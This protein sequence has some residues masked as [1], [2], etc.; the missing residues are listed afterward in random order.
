ML[1]AVFYALD[2]LLHRRESPSAVAPAARAPL[3]LEGTPN[4]LL[5]A[6]V[7]GAVLMSGL[8]D[9]GDRV[10]RRGRARSSSRARCAASSSSCSAARRSRSRR[11]PCARHNQFHWA[12]IVEVAKLFAAIFVTIFPVLAMLEAGRDGALAG[13][14]ELVSDGTGSRNNVMVFWL[15]GLLSAFLDNAPTY[16]VFFNLAGGDAA[17]LMGEH[18]Q[19]L[20]ALSMGAVYFGALTYIGNA[21]NF[22]IKAIAEDRGVAMPSFFAFFF[23]AVARPAAAARRGGGG[24]AVAAEARRLAEHEDVHAERPVRAEHDRLLDV[25]GARRAGDHVDR[26]R[27][28]RRARAG[29]ARTP[30]P[31]PTRRDR[32]GRRR[33]ACPAAASSRSACRPRPAPPAC[34]SRRSRRSAGDAEAV[35]ARRG[36]RFDRE[37]GRRPVEVGELGPAHARVRLLRRE[38][39][40]QV[41]RI[42]VARDGRGNLAAIGDPLDACSPC[43]SRA[44]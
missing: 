12:P 4:F 5:L 21:P 40:R 16:L 18:A 38:R 22:M 19:S 27:Q 26:A 34:R 7:I 1:L 11:P 2:A 43:R 13:I 8:W 14:F 32:R 24:L 15:T 44:A 37:A 20:A 41:E 25:A 39:R 28:L 31:C 33:R 9:P 23:Y 36:A 17:T 30:P 35:V 29:S 6:G 42:E 10:R 3:S